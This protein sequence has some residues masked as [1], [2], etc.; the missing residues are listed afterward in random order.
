MSLLAGGRAGAAA[1]LLA[2]RHPGDVVHVREQDHGRLLRRRRGRV[3]A[4]PRVRS[5]LRV[6]G[7]TSNKEGE[8]LLKSV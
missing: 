3:P 6:R 7:K 8:L 1:Q 2:G 4:L 5:G